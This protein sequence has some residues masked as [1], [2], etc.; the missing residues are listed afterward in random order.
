MTNAQLQELHRKFA[1]SGKLIEA[2]WISL[3]IAAIPL[4]APQVQIDEMR[5]AFMAGA[6]HVFA[7]IMQFLDP[8][9]DPTDADMRRMDLIAAELELFGKELQGRLRKPGR[10]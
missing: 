10:A 7:S 4:D 8:G 1:D 5:N 6:Q 3:R 9:E 2:G